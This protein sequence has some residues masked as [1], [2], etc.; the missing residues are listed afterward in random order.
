MLQSTSSGGRGRL[1]WQ[2]SALALIA[3]GAGA[4]KAEAAPGQAAGGLTIDIQ[5]QDTFNNTGPLNGLFSGSDA[6]PQD[7]Y[8][9]DGG[10]KPGSGYDIA[11][12]I[13]YQQPG[14][15]WSFG[16]G[17]RYGRMNGRSGN[18]HFA[19]S[20]TFTSY[21]G[22]KYSRTHAQ[23]THEK[24][25][26][27]SHYVID[28]EV[29]RDVGVGLFGRGVTTIGAGV[30]Y[31]HFD[32][33]VTG[34]F[35][36]SQKYGDSFYHSSHDF[37]FSRNGTFVARHTTDAAG[38]R[39]FVKTVS[40]FPGNTG[41]SLDGGVGLGLLFGRQ[42]VKATVDTHVTFGTGSY[43][44]VHGVSRSTSQTIPTVDGYL[45]ISWT[46]PNSPFTLGVGYRA[47]AYFTAIDGGY[48]QNREID[49]FEHGPYL[50]ASVRVP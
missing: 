22:G 19:S 7:Q 11:G 25:A 16:V 35:A 46:A 26:A 37:Q 8:G 27:S 34:S 50:D 3:V 9:K 31:A 40:P 6:I 5:G 43:A 13:T 14:S 17:V 42:T 47:D 38:P 49:V 2:V 48:A 29:G 23:T 12:T 44:G 18:S 33:T 15:P 10:L 39:V 36:T 32:S 4:R 24:L 1:F 28:F 41:L 21:Y 30:R 45:Q 20:S